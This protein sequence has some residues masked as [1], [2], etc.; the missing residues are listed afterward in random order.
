MENL[1]INIKPNGVGIITLNRPRVHNALDQAM[2]KELTA[3][4]KEMAE[5]D[6]VRVV[7]LAANGRSFCAGADLNDMRRLATMPEAEN[8]EAAMAMARMF[9]SLAELCK[10]TIALVQGTVMGGGVGLVAAADLV[11]A[12]RGAVFALSEVRLGLIPAVVSP[13]VVEAMGLRNAKRYFLTGEQF[14]AKQARRLGL[15][16]EVVR[17]DL[18]LSMSETLTESLLANGPQ[19]MAAVKRLMGAHRSPSLADIS[20]QKMAMLIAEI[21]GSDEGIEGVTAFL[22]KRNP[23]WQRGKV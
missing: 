9:K 5:D 14:S 12:V 13:Y 1:I 11:V 18:I 6:G 2:I 22:S 3:I 20:P 19:A 23:D 8:Y 10:P 17:H 4:F 7:V 16:H 15:V 21:R